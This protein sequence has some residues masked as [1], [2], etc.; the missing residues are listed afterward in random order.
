MRGRYGQHSPYGVYVSNE[1][2]P[3]TITE[4]EGSAVCINP[5]DGLGLSNTTSIRGFQAF[6]ISYTLP[7]SVIRGEEFVVVV[8]VFSYVDAALPV[9]KNLIFACINSVR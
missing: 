8:S 9:S 2:L 7:I 1:T 5:R 4:W 3:D 6:F